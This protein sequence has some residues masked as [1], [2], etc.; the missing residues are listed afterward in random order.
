[1][2]P[3]YIL[4]MIVEIESGHGRKEKF[5]LR[6]DSVLFKT[7]FQSDL[8]ARFTRYRGEVI[9]C[10]SLVDRCS[11]QDWI[12]VPCDFCSQIT[13]VDMIQHRTKTYFFICY[14]FNIISAYKGPLY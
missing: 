8:F 14:G 13:A 6:E 3:G 9:A 10:G 2:P 4:R 11:I 12:E 1:M 5:E 7:V